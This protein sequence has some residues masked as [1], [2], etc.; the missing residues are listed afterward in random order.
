MAGALALPVS[1]R[2]GSIEAD[3]LDRVIAAAGGRTLLS[4]VKALNWTGFARVCAGDKTLEIRVKTRVEPFVRARSESFLLN[5]PETART[6]IIEPERGFVERDGIRTALPARQIEHERQQY[7]VY[8][9]MLLAL[10]PTRLALEGRIL[11]QRPGFPPIAFATDGDHIATADYDVDSPDSGAP[12][13]Q[14]FIFEGEYF[15]KGVRWPQTITVLHTDKPF[16][17]LDLETFSVELA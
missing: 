9:Y 4:R 10:A 5:Q 7:G 15:D 16:L 14:V 2:A 8:G 1:A 6:L 17:T 11:S 12:I 13:A 3:L